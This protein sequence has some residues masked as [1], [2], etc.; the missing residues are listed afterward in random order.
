MLRV[1]RA[2]NQTGQK[3]AG[4]PDIAKTF[5][6]NHNFLLWALVL[7]TYINVVQRLSRRAVPWASRQLSTASAC[8][9][10]IA[11]LGFKVAFTK[12]DAPE[13]LNGLERFVLRPMEEAS[14]VAQ[15]RAVFAS[16]GILSLLTVSPAM[17]QK[18]S[19]G[20]PLKGSSSP[21]SS[22]TEQLT[23]TRS[24][25]PPP[26][27]LHPLP[28]NPIP[29]HQ[30]SPLPPFR[31]PIPIPQHPLPHAHRAHPNMS[32]FPIHLLL[33]L[34]RLQCNILRRSFQRLQ[35]RWRIQRR[36]RW[37]SHIC[38]QL[39]WALVVDLSDHAPAINE[40]CTRWRTPALAAA[41]IV[42]DDV[43]IQ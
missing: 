23:K 27:P 3:H 14:L 8:A 37:T 26:R 17:Y 7:G 6:L 19:S 41:S 36:S 5:L 20:A 18:V 34:R 2:W 32:S 30:H 22:K 39:G 29:H 35:R 21:P 43:R 16:I 1:L 33:R 25:C 40:A 24:R 42:V 9:L 10:G 13:L 38:W 28:H 31:T 12:A 4:E 15:A 11:A